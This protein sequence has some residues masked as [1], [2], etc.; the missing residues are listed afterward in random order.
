MTVVSRC[1]GNQFVLL[2]D[3]ITALV[4]LVKQTDICTFITLIGD[5]VNHTGNRIGTIQCRGAIFQNVD[6]RNGNLRNSGIK[7][8]VIG[9]LTIDQVQGSTGTQATQVG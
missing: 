6:T 2:L 1:T 9:T 5:D 7:V 4:F 8:T 3:Q